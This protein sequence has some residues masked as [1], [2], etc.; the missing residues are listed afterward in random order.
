MTHRATSIRPPAIAKR[1]IKQQKKKRKDSPWLQ[2]PPLPWTG[3]YQQRPPRVCLFSFLLRPTCLIRPHECAATQD[4]SH[5]RERVSPVQQA[6]RR[7]PEYLRH[8][9]EAA[10]AC[11]RVDRRAGGGPR[12]IACSQRLQP[13]RCELRHGIG[14]SRQL[15]FL[16]LR[17]ASCGGVLWPGCSRGCKRRGCLELELQPILR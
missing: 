3:P 17:P 13:H 7:R 12:G 9:E 8:T 2:W 4:M 15:T 16:G 5:L 1:N 11:C 10:V 6:A 14:A